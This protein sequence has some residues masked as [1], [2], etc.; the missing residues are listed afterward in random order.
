MRGQRAVFGPVRLVP[1]VGRGRRLGGSGQRCA[2]RPVQRT[3][4]GVDQRLPPDAVEEQEAREQLVIERLADEGCSLRL[5]QPD[6]DQYLGAARRGL[7]QLRKVGRRAELVDVEGEKLRQAQAAATSLLEGLSLED[8]AAVVTFGSEVRVLRELSLER[9]PAIAAVAALQA[10]GN[11]ALYE[12]VEQSA[13]LASETDLTRRAVVLLTDGEN[14][15]DEPAVSRAESIAF[16]AKSPA[17]FYVVGVGPSI[18]RLYLEEIA[19]ASGGQFFHAEGAADVPAIYAALEERLRSQFVV[20]VE[21]AAAAAS[22]ARSVEV[23]LE[24]GLSSV[25][26]T[27]SYGS[28]RP[29]AAPTPEPTVAVTPSPAAAA[30]PAATTAPITVAQAPETEGG[31]IPVPA[32]GAGVFLLLAIG[33]AYAWVRRRGRVTRFA[34]ALPTARAIE[35]AVPEPRHRRD[36]VVA[37]PGERA[38][39]FELGTEPVTLGSGGRSEIQLPAL[40]AIAAEHARLWLRDGQPMLHHL[41]PGYITLLNERPV[42]WASMNDGD[43]LR[44]GAVAITIGRPVEAEEGSLAMAGD[45]R[46]D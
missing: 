35:R 45:R 29:P 14:F 28:L 23:T 11:T 46:G 25:T 9:E 4:D 2:H 39:T 3:A 37:A 5:G 15:G 31:G 21:S 30:T 8:A 12:A 43:E 27:A 41:A 22:R 18:D 20:T 26:V 34:D 6:D 38:V 40:P 19:A 10:S 13:R 24:R 17:L 32:V 36:I 33:G 44:I 16:A 7:L 42:E 1:R